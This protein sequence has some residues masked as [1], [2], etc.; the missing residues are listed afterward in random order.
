MSIRGTKVVG[1]CR[2]RGEVGD[3]CHSHVLPEFMY[4]PMYDQNHRFV[5]LSASGSGESEP[6]QKGYRE[7]LLC[8]DCEGYFGE[9]ERQVAPVFRS[10]RQ[11]LHGASPNAVIRL[12]TQ[13]AS[14]KLFMLSLLWRAS[15]AKHANY[16]AV[17]LASLEPIVRRMLCSATPGS[18]AAFPIVARAYAN[19]D[20]LEG[21]IGIWGRNV[22]N[23]IPLVWLDISG[24]RWIYYL[25]P[26]VA[27]LAT[28]PP[29]AVTRNELRVFVG[30]KDESEFHQKLIPLV[31]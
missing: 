23:G 2:L 13:Y 22:S 29:V 18:E 1:K 17:D 25:S 31:R 4:E 19:V 27:S 9:W 7:Y 30:T 28:V 15:I 14:L 6:V 24:V 26:Q 10:L 3:L 20:R 8:R 12:P 21:V 11:R 16:A 5:A